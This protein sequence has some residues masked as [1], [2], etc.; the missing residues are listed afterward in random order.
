M[1]ASAAVILILKEKYRVC[2]IQNLKFDLPKLS[3]PSNLKPQSTTSLCYG[4]ENILLGKNNYL[5]ITSW[6]QGYLTCGF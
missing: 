4:I 5:Q 1:A 2:N 6:C 3:Q